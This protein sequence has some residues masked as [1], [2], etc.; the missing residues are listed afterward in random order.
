MKHSFQMANLMQ[1]TPHVKPSNSNSLVELHRQV[2]QHKMGTN[3]PTLE[4]FNAKPFHHN[5][6]PLKAPNMRNVNYLAPPHLSH[7][8]TVASQ[9][10]YPMPSVTSILGPS[11]G[12]GIEAVNWCAHCSMT[13]RLTSDLVQ[14]MRNFHSTDSPNSS[15]DSRGSLT[16]GG[17]NSKSKNCGKNFQCSSC[18]EN[19][20]ERHHLTRHLS[21][22]TT[23][24]NRLSSHSNK[25]ILESSPVVKSKR[26]I[27]KNETDCTEDAVTSK[28]A[29]QG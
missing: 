12:S 1:N 21:S 3:N 20:K 2:E 15:N 22:H 27:D 9:P 16:A 5:G 29:K 19:F 13:F 24:I 18:G 28:S 4:H 25:S 6:V 11:L 10:A 7:P 26:A 23:P 14:H 8:S 17:N